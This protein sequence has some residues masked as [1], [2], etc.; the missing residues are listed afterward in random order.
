MDFHP[1]MNFPNECMAYEWIKGFKIKTRK[2]L[3]DFLKCAIQNHKWDIINFLSVRV[4]QI[5]QK[6]YN[7][8]SLQIIS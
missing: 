1:W 6:K 8:K 5:Q 7:N 4:P 3:Q 2:F